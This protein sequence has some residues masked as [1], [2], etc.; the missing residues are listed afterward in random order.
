MFLSVSKG[1]LNQLFY[2]MP[3][4]LTS[5]IIATI[6]MK[7]IK[8]THVLFKD[9]IQKSELHDADYCVKMLTKI[10]IGYLTQRILDTESEM[11]IEKDSKELSL[12]IN[13]YLNKKIGAER[14]GAI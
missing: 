12:I 8:L 14:A 5:Q 11:D 13:L 3:H 1:S 6:E 7:A 10:V 2:A 4:L 9:Q